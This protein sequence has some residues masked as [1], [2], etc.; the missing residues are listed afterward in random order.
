MLNKRTRI[1]F[2]SRATDRNSGVPGG[3]MEYQVV[4]P[5]LPSHDFLGTMSD[6]SNSASHDR[7]FDVLFE[8]MDATD[9][10]TARPNFSRQDEAFGLALLSLALKLNHVT[11]VTESL[12]LI[13]TDHLSR[14]VNLDIDLRNLTAQQ[15]E[16][17][18]AHEHA[19]HTDDQLG[20]LQARRAPMLWVP[21]SRHSREDLAP[22][23]VRDAEATAVPRLTQTAVTK[24]V[25][26]G[27]TWL[28]RA[29]LKAVL[30]ENGAALSAEDFDVPTYYQ[31]QRARWLIEEAIA[32]LVEHG[33]HGKPTPRKRLRPGADPT[34]DRAEGYV[35]QL[36]EHTTKHLGDLLNAVS[37]EYF[38]IVMLPA[39]QSHQFLTYEAP[40]I[41][42][43]RST[44]A[45][46][47]AWRSLLPVSTEFT[48]SYVTQ[49]PRSV[50]S[51]H[52][53]ID[54][55]EE[56]D[57]RRFILS[58]N[59]DQPAVEDLANRIDAVVDAATQAGDH[60]KVIEA[61][62]KE[63]E[64]ALGVLGQR[65]RLDLQGFDYYLQNRELKGSRKWSRSRAAWSITRW[66][67][68][69]GV[70]A[71]ESRKT[72]AELQLLQPDLQLPQPDLPAL[73]RRLRDHHLGYDV[74]TDN[75][76]RE[77][78]AHAQWR[79]VPLGFGYPTIE[80]VEA[81]VYL[82]MAD[83]PPALVEGVVWMLA[84]LLI[85]VLGLNLIASGLEPKEQFAEA[86]AVV[87]VLLIVPGILLRRL[88]IPSTHS[89]LGRLRRFPRMVAYLSVGITTALA[90]IVAIQ[91]KER[92][93][94]F[95]VGAVL[96]VILLLL[97]FVEVF[98]R[99]VRRRVLVPA[100]DT[101][102]SWLREQ[103]ASASNAL[104]I[105]PRVPG[106]GP[107]IHPPDVY[108]DAIRPVPNTTKVASREYE[109]KAARRRYRS[110]T[111]STNATEGPALLAEV[112]ARA[113]AGDNSYTW[114]K[115]GH[116]TGTGQL[117]WSPGRGFVV[118]EL[119]FSTFRGVAC[120]V[121]SGYIKAGDV[122]SPEHVLISPE[123]DPARAVG[124]GQQSA[125]ATP[126]ATG[127]VQW[128][129]M[130]QLEPLAFRP[131]THDV[132]F[133]IEF[134]GV[135]AIEPGRMLGFLQKALAAAAQIPVWPTL[136]LSPA[137]TAAM[138]EDGHALR[139]KAS[140]PTLRLTFT[141]PHG[142]HK[143]R[144]ELEL[145][146]VK[147]AAAGNVILSRASRRPGAGQGDW[148]RL[149]T[150]NQVSA[151]S[152][153]GRSPG[154]LIPMTFAGRS[155]VDGLTSFERLTKA[156]YDTEARVVS[157]TASSVSQHG[158]VQIVVEASAAEHAPEHESRLTADG[159][160]AFLRDVGALGKTDPTLPDLKGIEFHTYVG[161]AE[162]Q[163]SLYRMGDERRALWVDWE[164]PARAVDIKALA[165]LIVTAC[166]DHIGVSQIAYWRMI[167]TPD[168]HIQGR[169][170][171]A[172]S[173]E[174]EGSSASDLGNLAKQA[175]T[176]MVAVLQ[177][178]FAGLPQQE[179]FLHVVWSE[180]WLVR[181]RGV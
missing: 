88:D 46:R 10:P 58:S 95:T 24:A 53:T 85:V 72:K 173:P 100:S 87:A 142:D 21:I 160:F 71:E 125:V 36:A 128:E 90:M 118:E 44:T 75:D 108:F 145:K 99:S 152:K 77:N 104:R 35:M 141:M 153:I 20:S 139:P 92:I 66:A 70:H 42:A 86:D 29:Q 93:S 132:D 38:L 56:I 119:L 16:V 61:E 11:R 97:C 136:V 171:L 47:R 82:A 79:P 84:A 28:F 148:Q 143:N 50:G 81:R 62:Q 59:A 117:P 13:N 115:I 113:V 17:L 120:Q 102:P 179:I 2:V 43:V 170:K 158:V 130:A 163:S 73:A 80:P 57:V 149:H 122:Q 18:K 96:L 12:R 103:F 114:V 135:S 175:Q 161:P 83:E 156:L 6:S 19:S 74:S 37:R 172:V 137:A 51:Y 1:P 32:H 101:I 30:G 107:R 69:L 150:P 22:V 144:L 15:R 159:A 48:V 63:I 3:Q 31:D 129:D 78:G 140:G 54:V 167:R 39:G 154:Q 111:G 126:P 112:G 155:G 52:V 147:I 124:P 116:G 26:A 9:I 55:P 109:A 123:E 89:V 169:A 164:L 176:S 60:S 165:D 34:R 65:R 138:D 131:N 166:K 7:R 174:A 181:R 178:K 94:A 5:P 121:A 134:P 64:S 127:T 177:R 67:E 8:T 40:L 133:L 68:L 4:S 45:R 146:M 41:P 49:L 91:G 106:R 157:L 105:G 110:E 23:I 76:P 168:D 27:V 180:P 33:S 25:I 98:A 151:R 162:G 14:V